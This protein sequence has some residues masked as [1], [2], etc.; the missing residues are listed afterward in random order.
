MGSHESTL[1]PSV[2]ERADR[3]WSNDH[4]ETAFDIFVRLGFLQLDD[5]IPAALATALSR[6]Y[7]ERYRVRTRAELE[8]ASLQVG[9]R[10]FMVT[11]EM[12]PPFD[13][14]DVYA[15]PFVFPLLTR[16]LGTQ[17][18]L[19]SAGLV[20]ALAG[21]REQHIHRDHPPLF[22]EVPIGPM[23]PCYAVTL[24]VPL[25]DLDQATVGTT[26]VWPG[27][28]REARPHEG[29]TFDTAF[30]PA[31]RLGSAYVMDYRLLHAG[32]ANRSDT[33]RAILYFLYARPW[34]TDA[35]N[36]S[37]QATISMSPER[38]AAVPETHRS[39]F[40]QIS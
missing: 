26:A 21:S 35:Q 22:P 3:Q 19:R 38:L 23:L 5:V 18:V 29:R 17:A 39:L 4:L 36:Y 8:A 11:L 14:V 40:T 12:E 6:A 30:F 10:R 16:L 37:H 32:T 33:S 27:T 13:D 7:E 2:S 15:N 9:H 28:H 20:I 31:P 24:V 25:I 1:V 34:F